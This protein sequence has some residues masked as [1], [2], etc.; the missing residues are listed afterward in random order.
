MTID[1][2]RPIETNDY[3]PRSVRFR[4]VKIVKWLNIYSDTAIIGYNTRKEADSMAGAQRIACV[5]VEFE[6]G[7]FDK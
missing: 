2:T 6:D 3:H 5:R 1:W 7:Q 4:N